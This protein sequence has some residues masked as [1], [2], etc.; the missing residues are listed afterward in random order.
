MKLDVNIIRN[1]AVFVLFLISIDINNDMV[2][3]RTSEVVM[4][5]V[6]LI[7]WMWDLWKLFRLKCN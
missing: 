2:S 6:S 7:V 1:R 3:L 5:L 4:T